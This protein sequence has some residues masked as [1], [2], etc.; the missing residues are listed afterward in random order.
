MNVIYEM[1]SLVRSESFIILKSELNLFIDND[2]WRCGARIQ[3][4]DL[5]YCTKNLL[6]LPRDNYFAKLL[7]LFN[8]ICSANQ[9]T[10]FYMITASVMK[11][12]KVH[13]RRLI[14]LDR[15]IV[16]QTEWATV[17]KI[18][19]NEG[20]SYNYPTAGPSPQERVMFDYAFSY[21][22][23]YYAGPEFAKS[24]FNKKKKC[25][26]QIMDHFIHMFQ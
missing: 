6:I 19:K 14:I 5:L 10:G 4:A 26:V 13:V 20:K 21:V 24:I 2:L 25:Y 16:F 8:M 15:N 3:N 11:E 23:V 18:I 7:V 12:L 17:R 22:G 9:W 1:K